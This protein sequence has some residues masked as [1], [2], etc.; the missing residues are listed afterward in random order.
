[1][2]WRFI[3]EHDSKWLLQLGKKHHEESD[4]SKVK[5]S[6]DKCKK[7]I[8]T[9]TNDPNY[10]SIVLEKQL[11]EQGMHRKA[12]K[13]DLKLVLRLVLHLHMLLG[14]LKVIKKLRQK[15]IN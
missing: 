4:W 9:A 10:F 8:H 12:V 15:Q 6:E 5:F 2:D 13:Q 7:Y 14:K 1:M 3:E 11:V